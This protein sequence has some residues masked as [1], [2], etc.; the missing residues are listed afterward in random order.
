MRL[1][2]QLYVLDLTDDWKGVYSPFGHKVVFIENV[3]WHNLQNGLIDKVDQSLADYLVESNVLVK[4]N[5]EE[6]WLAEQDASETIAFNWMY[7]VLTTECNLACKYCAVLGNE[8]ETKKYATDMSLEVGRAAINFYERHLHETQPY[9]ARVTLYGGEPLLKKELLFDLIPR[10]R[11]I[12]YP[13]MGNPIEICIITNG[14]IYDPEITKLF[15]EYSVDLSISMD[16]KKEHH[17]LARVTPEGDG[18]FDTVL[19]NYHKYLEAGLL[20]SISNTIGKHN[21]NSLSEIAEYYVKELQSNLV[22]FQIPCE[23]PGHN[24]LWVSTSEAS[25]HLMKAT[26]VLHSYGAYEGT[27]LRRLED[28]ARGRVRIRDCKS[29]GSQLVVA[30]DGMMGPCHSLVGSRK[31]FSGNIT[32]KNCDPT[33]L[34]NFKEW[35]KRFP[36]NMDSCKKCSF[37]TLCGGGCI[38]NTYVTSGSIWNKDPQ[39]C[40]YMRT[41]VEWIL[42]D[43]WKKTGMADEYGLK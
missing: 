17:D 30:P 2:K 19:A 4:E 28:F 29:S 43:L 8:D 11:N 26:E 32:D 34:D 10:L 16:G 27:N 5:F 37:V 20:I 14:Y 1:S 40:T 13:N 21:V 15:K 22:E 41:L 25:A 3:D 23:I 35:A 36:L 7:L 6:T 33:K 39:S 31:Y 9:V 12:K 18:T 38:Y 42:K 24:P